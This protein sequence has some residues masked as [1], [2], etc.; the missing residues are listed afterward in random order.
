MLKRIPQPSEP[1][2][3]DVVLIFKEEEKYKDLIHFTFIILEINPDRLYERTVKL[4]QYNGKPI[5]LLSDPSSD[6]WTK[7]D[8]IQIE[9]R[10]VDG[11]DFYYQTE[12]SEKENPN[13]K[14]SES[15][16]WEL[17]DPDL[18]DLFD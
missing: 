8:F 2:V 15:G 9:K 16:W 10:T 12:L 1:L 6:Y 18:L 3:G 14:D 4:G 11:Y 17:I 7:R 13:K 5:R